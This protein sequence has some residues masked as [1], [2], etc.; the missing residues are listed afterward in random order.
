MG[1][2]GR[3]SPIIVSYIRFTLWGLDGIA[4]M[5]DDY[6]AFLV[7]CKSCVDILLPLTITMSSRFDWLRPCSRE[8]LMVRAD[9]E[10]GLSLSY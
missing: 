7:V 2:N 4:G 1:L 6:D 5:K 10:M 3:D 8:I 9:G